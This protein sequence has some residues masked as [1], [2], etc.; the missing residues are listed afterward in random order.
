MSMWH[1]IQ[2]LIA[3]QR[4]SVLNTKAQL[5]Q[6]VGCL[7]CG[8]TQPPFALPEDPFL[9]ISDSLVALEKTFAE[10]FRSRGQSIS[11][12]VKPSPLTNTVLFSSV[13]LIISKVYNIINVRQAQA[14]Q[15]ESRDLG[16]ISWITFIVFPLISISVLIPHLFVPL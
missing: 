13:L 8:D 9:Q 12:L 7:N 6:L 11:D 4:E 5:T 3:T 16:R 14:A 1:V 15:Q 10:D 2:K